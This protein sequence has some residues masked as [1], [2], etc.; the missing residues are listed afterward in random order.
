MP[1][2]FEVDSSMFKDLAGFYDV[3]QCTKFRQANPDGATTFKGDDISWG[4]LPSVEGAARSWLNDATSGSLAVQKQAPSASYSEITHLL[5]LTLVAS[6]PDW[7]CTNCSDMM[8]GKT[9]LCLSGDTFVAG[10][11]LMFFKKSGKSIV[12]CSTALGQMSR[13]ELH[14]NGE[15]FSF[16]KSHQAITI[17]HQDKVRFRNHIS[18]LPQPNFG[19]STTKIRHASAT[20]KRHFRNQK[21]TDFATKNNRFRNQKKT[22]PQPKKGDSATKTR[23]FRNQKKAIPQPPSAWLRNQHPRHNCGHSQHS[24]VSR[25]RGGGVGWGGVG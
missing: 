13:N 23:G 20:K 12:D 9:I 17:P 10:I 6:G 3:V 19:D 16:L 21:R 22:I 25:F 2:F 8:F 15:F 14:E 18:T 5:S 11:P 24:I 4:L 7:E 1:T